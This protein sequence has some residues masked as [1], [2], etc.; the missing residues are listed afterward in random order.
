MTSFQAPTG[1]RDILF[2]ESA[3]FAYLVATFSKETTLAGYGLAVSPMFEELGVFSRA[4]GTDSD[5]VGKEMYQFEDRGGRHL[6]LRPEGTASVVRAFVQHRPQVPW[7]AWYVTPAFRY[8]RPQA[9]RYRQHHQL[10]VEALG[11]DDPD[12]DVEVVALLVRYFTRV[13]LSSMALRINS[14]GDQECR[15]GYRFALSTYFSSVSERLCPEHRETWAKNPFRI[16][17]C[18][19]PECQLV[20]IEAPRFSEF[21]C[22]PCRA[23]FAR[24]L[25]GLSSLHIDFEQDDFLVRGFDY[26]T[27]TTFEVISGALEAAQNAIGGGGRYN[28]LAEALG[29]PPTPGIG[30]GTGIERVLLAAEAEGLFAAETPSVEVFIIDL[31]SGEEALELTHRLRSSGISCDRAFD[32]RS[33][34]AQLRAADRSGARLAL[35]VGNDELKCATVTIRVLRGEDAHHQEQVERSNLVDRV[36]ELLA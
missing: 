7:K 29:G 5:V 33:L 32:G 35:V 19:K 6:A 14:M 16:L 13:G 34:K 20:R 4:I 8:E 25:A 2:P 22:D 12:L 9:G 21:W 18:K 24:V 17:D 31:V 26:Y 11:S 30:F 36:K 3:H 27:R 15:P 28:G 23:H 10:G 1:T